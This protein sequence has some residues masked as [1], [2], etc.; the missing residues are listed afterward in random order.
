MSEVLYRKYR[1]QTFSDV[2]GQEYITTTLKN[3]LA[4]GQVS[5]AYLFAGPRGTGKTS[6]A[7][8]LAKAVNCAVGANSSTFEFDK[9]TSKVS[10][11]ADTVSVEPCNKCDACIGITNGTFLDLIEI[12]AASNRGID[13]VRELRE[14]VNFQPAVGK[15]KIYIL[16]EVHMLTKEAFN[17]LLKTLEEPPEHVMFILCTTEPYKVPDTI[18][19]RCQRFDF[20]LSDEVTLKSYILENAK[21][22][23]VKLDNDAATLIAQI[24]NGAY[25]DAIGLLEQIITYKSKNKEQ[26]TKV[27]LEDVRG[28]L[29]LP[30][31]EQIEELLTKV[32]QKDTRNL[33][34]FVALL[35]ESGI[36]LHQFIKETIEFLRR[37]LLLGLEKKGAGIKFQQGEIVRLIT[38]LSKAEQEMKFAVIPQLPL[39]LALLEFVVNPTGSASPSVQVSSERKSF[40]HTASQNNSVETFAPGHSL[41]QKEEGLEQ[42]WPQVLAQVKPKNHTIEALLKGCRPESLEND[43]L[44]LQFFYPFHKEKIEEA[45]NRKIVEEAVAEALGRKVRIRCVLSDTPKSK[46][47]A[48]ATVVSSEISDEEMKKIA[49][50]IFGGEK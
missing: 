12:D 8:I 27:N 31:Q 39:E 14:K 44:T 23:K 36:N 21:K 10:L 28:M 49:E 18:M 37:E 35:Y 19:S 30:E 5:H 32:V 29:G 46:T 11:G 6:V 26:R 22:E 47:R 50:E 40:T 24:A 25:R 20:Q 9:E 16:D 15:K 42:I 1:P 3:A 17:A 4:S 13:D 41:R 2:V 45:R 33:L 34:K 43:I 38:L 48:T 7:R